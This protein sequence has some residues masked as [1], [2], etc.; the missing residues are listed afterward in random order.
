M[1]PKIKFIQNIQYDMDYISH[2]VSPHKGDWDWSDK[3]FY[4]HPGLKNRLKSVK[5]NKKRDK[6][7]KNYVEE[8]FKNPKNFLELEKRKKEIQ[9]KWIKIHDKFISCL[10]NIF[11][12]RNHNIKDITCSVSINPINP[13]ELNTNFFSVF[14]KY[15]INSILVIIAHEITHFFYFDKW[16]KA[17]PNSDPKTF[18]GPHIIW[19]LSEIIAPIILAE[20]EIQKLLK[21]IDTGYIE[22]GKIR[23]GD[24]N[25][26]EH[27]DFLYKNFD[28]KKDFSEFLKEAYKEIM[29]YEKELNEL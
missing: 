11:N 3:I 23:I 6:I 26:I 27:F 17:F 28:K 22:H 8:W 24:K 16:K 14:Y 1:I 4:F 20:P 13:R 9:E 7:V 10:L 15:N 5:D 21:K 2:F 18:E 19:H 25:I 12:L 29:K